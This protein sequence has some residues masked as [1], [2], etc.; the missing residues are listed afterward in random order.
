MQKVANK[1]LSIY[2]LVMLA[3][4]WGGRAILN[5]IFSDLEF[6][7]YP[8]IPAVFFVMGISTILVLAKNYKLEGKKLVNLY[9]VLKLVKLIFAMSYVLGFYFIVRAD[10]RTFG[11]VFA[12]FYAIYIACEFYIFYSIEK[13]I[14]KEA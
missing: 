6:S 9:M 5:S 11:F 12:I 13:Q 7:W 4:G 2:A 1:L 3:A 8:Y 10:L 14:K